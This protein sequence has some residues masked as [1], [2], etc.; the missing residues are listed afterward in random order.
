MYAGFEASSP[1]RVA[2][3]L[4]ALGQPTDRFYG[5]ANSFRCPLG[6]D[7]GRG[8]VLLPY[9][10]VQQLDF[11]T[12]A[13]LTFSATDAATATPYSV[14]LKNLLAVGAEAVHPGRAL[15]PN[16]PYV[17]ELRDRRVLYTKYGVQKGYNVRNP[18]DG[19]YYAATENSGTPWTWDLL[20]A[21]LWA[22][23]GGQLGT[24]PG[25]PFS[26]DG[27]PDNWEFW[28]DYAWESLGKFLRRLGCDLRL[29]PVADTLTIIRLN[30]AD[31]AADSAATTYYPLRVDD[32]Y[33][34]ASARA[35]IPAS[36]RVRFAV[37]PLTKGVTPFYGVD[38]ADPTGNATGPGIDPNTFVIIDDDLAAVSNGSGGYT[39]SAALASR[40]AERAADYFRQAWGDIAP[41]RIYYAAPLSAAGLLPGAA[42]DAT[43][44]MDLGY[45]RGR[46]AGMLTGVERRPDFRAA[47]W[48][49]E[50]LRFLSPG[51][52]GGSITVDGV[53]PG[54]G[55]PSSPPNPHLTGITVIETDWATGLS[56]VSDAGAAKLSLQAASGTHAGAV[57]T[58]LQVFAGDKFIDGKLGLSNNTAGTGTLPAF[59]YATVYSYALGATAPGVKLHTNSGT[60]DLGYLYTTGVAAADATAGAAA[61]SG[62]WFEHTGATNGG[63]AVQG[64]QFR[65]T[66]TTFNNALIPV[67]FCVS[68]SPVFRPTFS[69]S[70]TSHFVV[71]GWVH[72]E[73]GFETWDGTAVKTGLTQTDVVSLAGGGSVTQK[74]VNG[75]RVS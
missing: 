59:E 27:T 15:D 54:T 67:N 41:K 51:G 21:D 44:W 26:P 9:A 33:F 19:T 75:I 63:T 50:T 74:F 25:L 22:A 35:T 24:W 53:D 2:A 55:D 3:D 4:A 18:S 1:R 34:Y 66:N 28:N 30:A 12:P 65:F 8:W 46:F 36:A 6:T 69:N 43:T 38:V 60:N 68:P 7:A 56:L 40:A 73:S 17:V 48:E 31:A 23:V 39:N 72:A 5:K 49:P 14:T 13:D 62:W 42:T 32:G 61:G 52:A 45:E 47:R 10:S 64:F 16:A 20:G 37:L 71:M 57:S 70:A 11:L 29:D 58:G